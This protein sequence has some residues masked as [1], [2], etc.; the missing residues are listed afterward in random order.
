VT[1]IVQSG[2]LALTYETK[3]KSQMLAETGKYSMFTLAGYF[4][5]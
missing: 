2:F 1:Y 3:K 5:Y 4:L